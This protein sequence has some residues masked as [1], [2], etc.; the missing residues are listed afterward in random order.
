MVRIL[1]K[2]F[3]VINLL[4]LA[5]AAWLV[6]HLFIVVLQDR[7]PPSPNPGLAKGVRAVLA[8]KLEPYERYALVTERNIF[9]PA[10]KGLKLLPLGEKKPIE[11]KAGEASETG[12]APAGSYQLVGT[13]IGPGIHSYAIIQEGADSKQRIYRFNDSIGGGKLVRFFQ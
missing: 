2:N 6:A 9:N 13:V 1:T 3:W 8:E 10:E 4:F 7:L 11:G 12:K 5:A